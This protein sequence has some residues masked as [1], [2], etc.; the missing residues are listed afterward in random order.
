MK[1]W[2]I[3]NSIHYVDKEIPDAT[4]LIGINQNKTDTQNFGEKI[5]DI[6]KKNTRYK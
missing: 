6:D 3:Q 1:L 4:T 2:K 5:R